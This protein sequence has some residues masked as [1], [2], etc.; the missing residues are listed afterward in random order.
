MDSDVLCLHV[1]EWLLCCLTGCMLRHTLWT[2]RKHIEVSPSL[3]NLSYLDQSCN[4]LDLTKRL[5]HAKQHLANEATPLTP[6]CKLWKITATAS[7]KVHDSHSLSQIYSCTC[8][9]SALLNLYEVK[10]ST[11]WVNFRLHSPHHYLGTL[12]KVTSVPP[13]RHLKPSA[14]PCLALQRTRPRLCTFS[15]AVTHK[16]QMSLT[17]PDI[18]WLWNVMPWFATTSE[19]QLTSFLDGAHWQIIS[20]FPQPFGFR[21]WLSH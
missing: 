21:P 9:Q 17:Y 15:R 3:L 6:K 19:H 8:K 10:R 12:S 1:F 4:L 14:K 2:S 18:L 13:P 7:S 16:L 11:N 5:A 20:M